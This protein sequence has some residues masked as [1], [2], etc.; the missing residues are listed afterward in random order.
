MWT[1]P[2]CSAWS[3][4]FPGLLPWHDAVDVLDRI[5]PVLGSSSSPSRCWPSSPTRHRSSTSRPSRVARWGARKRAGLFLL[6]CAARHHHHDPAQPRHDRGAAHPG[7]ARR[8]PTTR[9]AAVP[10]ALAAVWL[11]NTASLLLPVSNLTNLL[12]INR[13]DMS[14]VEYASHMWL[15]ALAAVLVTVA[16]LF[17]VHR[18]Q[19]RGRYY[20]SRLQCAGRST[21]VRHLRSALPGHRAGGGRRRH[22]ME[23]CRARSS[24]RCYRNPLA[25]SRSTVPAARAVVVDDSDR[26]T[27]P[28][29]FRCRETRSRRFATS[30]AGLVR[31]DPSSRG[32]R[33]YEQCR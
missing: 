24:Y 3:R 21:A 20:D 17:L 19:L 25:L 22:A 12:A 11:A 6:I 33:R 8:C 31:H 16:Y 28:G 2:G 23:S 27:F 7:R 26:R 4:S 14:T 18:R 10:F 13:L 1:S 15:P 9:T 5:W 30:R 32:C 29:R